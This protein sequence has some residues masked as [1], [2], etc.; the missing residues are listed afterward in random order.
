LKILIVDDN[1]RIR[2]LIKKNLVKLDENNMLIECDDGEDAI[3]LFNTHSPDLVLMDIMMK[4]MDGFSAIKKILLKSPTAKI[5]VISQL[6][7]QEYKQEAFNCGAV[8][9]LNKENLYLL[10][11]MIPKHLG[12]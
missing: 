5:I 6:P 3:D 11:Q 1:T 4:R 12:K 7:E 2:E 8:D 10:G 9:Y